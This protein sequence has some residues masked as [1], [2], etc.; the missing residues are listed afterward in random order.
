MTP[1]RTGKMQTFTPTPTHIQAQFSDAINFV[2]YCLGLYYKPV[3]NIISVQTA[4]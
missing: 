3:I 2:I 1:L 4:I